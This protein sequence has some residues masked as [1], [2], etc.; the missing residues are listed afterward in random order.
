MEFIGTFF[1]RILEYSMK[2]RTSFSKLKIMRTA[3]QNS[4][5]KCGVLVDNKYWPSKEKLS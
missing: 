1:L 2:V 5:K 4:I 3:I